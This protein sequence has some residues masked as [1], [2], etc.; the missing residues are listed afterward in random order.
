MTIQVSSEWNCR[1][2]NTIENK[3][4][5]KLTSLPPS[6]C[7]YQTLIA[8]DFVIFPPQIPRLLLS[9]KTYRLI[10]LVTNSK[11]NSKSQKKDSCRHPSIDRLL[12]SSNAFSQVLTQPQLNQQHW[13]H[14]RQ[15]PACREAM[16]AIAEHRQSQ[17]TPGY[18]RRVLEFKS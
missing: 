9:H 10:S 8:R 4:T 1:R 13:A 2:K 12:Q 7:N 3:I 6:P 14:R 18:F 15:P 5:Q 17:L 16:K 11:S